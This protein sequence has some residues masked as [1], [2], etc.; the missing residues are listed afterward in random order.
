MEAKKD[1]RCSFR[2]LL[3]KELRKSFKIWCA[4]LDID[5]NARLISLI[6][7]DLKKQGKKLN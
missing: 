4:E 7:E 5:M 2:L 3:D 6:E 1:K